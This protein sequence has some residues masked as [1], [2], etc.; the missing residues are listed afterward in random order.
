M[1]TSAIICVQNVSLG[2][3]YQ[4][5]GSGDVPG[6]WGFGAHPWTSPSIGSFSDGQLGE[7]G[8]SISRKEVGPCRNDLGGRSYL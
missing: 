4:L 7:I 6:S 3:G 2:P 5:T 8:G 1:N